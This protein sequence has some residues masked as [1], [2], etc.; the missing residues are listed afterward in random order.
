MNEIED[1]EA[2][3]AAVAAFLDGLA[4]EMDRLPAMAPA[5]RQQ[6]AA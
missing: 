5:E 4:Q 6:E 2:Q 3:Y 1:C